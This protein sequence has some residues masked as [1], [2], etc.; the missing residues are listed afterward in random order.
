MAKAAPDIVEFVTDP[1]LL[2]R[3]PAHRGR[4]L[5]SS[6]EARPGTPDEAPLAGGVAAGA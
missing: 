4:K 6:G 5:A 1:A 3:I 2:G